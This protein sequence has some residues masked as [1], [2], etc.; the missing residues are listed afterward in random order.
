MVLCDGKH[1]ANIDF[2]WIE[3][4]PTID[5][6]N[7]PIPP[8]LK[9]MLKKSKA[10]PE[11]CDLCWDALHVLHVNKDEVVAC[12]Q[13]HLTKVEPALTNA[14]YHDTLTGNM[15]ERMQ[16]MPRRALDRELDKSYWLS[17][18]QMKDAA[19]DIGRVRFGTKSKD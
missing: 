2:G 18:T 13:R 15:V 10:W 1:F 11:F 9:E 6:E 4:A 7:F 12:W 16:N 17:Q 19:H 8:L 14:Y 3:E 5:T